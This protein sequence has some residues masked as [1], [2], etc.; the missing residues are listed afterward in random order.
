MIFEELMPRFLDALHIPS[1]ERSRIVLKLLG[2][3]IGANFLSLDDDFHTTWKPRDI[4]HNFLVLDKGEFGSFLVYTAEVFKVFDGS[5]G[6]GIVSLLNRRQYGLTFVSVPMGESGIIYAYSY[7]RLSEEIWTNFAFL[8]MSLRRQIGL[9]ELVSRQGWTREQLGIKSEPCPLFEADTSA[10]ISL[11]ATPIFDPMT[12]TFATGLWV[13]DAETQEFHHH[14]KSFLPYANQDDVY[15]YPSADSD[16]F[17]LSDVRIE[18]HYSHGALSSMIPVRE[19]DALVRIEQ[20][21]H[22]ELGWG[23]Q[24][25]QT[26]AFFTNV[27]AGSQDSSV[28]EFEASRLANVLNHISYQAVLSDTDNNIPELSSGSWVARNDQIYFGSF[29]PATVLKDLA[30]ESVGAFGYSLSLLLTPANAI[31]RAEILMNYLRDNE[32]ETKREPIPSHDYWAGCTDTMLHWPAIIQA[33]P[34][35]D[36]SHYGADFSTPVTTTVAS[37]GLFKGQPVVFSL[38]IVRNPATSAISLVRRHRYPDDAG[39]FVVFGPSAHISKSDLDEAISQYLGNLK[40]PRIDWCQIQSADFE[41]AVR[42][43]LRSYA[44]NLSSETDVEMIFSEIFQAQSPWDLLMNIEYSNVFNSEMSIEAGFEWVVTLPTVVDSAVSRLT[45]LFEHS[46]LK[47]AGASE[48]NLVASQ[49]VSEYFLRMR[50]AEIEVSTTYEEFLRDF[51]DANDDLID[52][53]LAR[54]QAQ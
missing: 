31:K 38:E 8:T 2:E 29:L 35:E 11:L 28:G 13:S 6:L 49:T 9:V 25:T 14:M 36:Q 42:T 3:E 48:L 30:D 47:T 39:S 24:E 40:L 43:G 41:E 37:W 1:A 45:A 34:E 16:V 7:T 23:I 51:F 27:K 50:M 19:Y 52:Q 53:L 12:P 21:R 18:A 26:F 22:P 46:S 4:E 32:L 44:H 15:R 10:P 5:A 33:L 54:W 20:I 17:V